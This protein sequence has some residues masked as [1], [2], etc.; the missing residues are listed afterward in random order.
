MKK[1]IIS[2]LLPVGFL[3]VLLFSGCKKSD[4]GPVILPP[5]PPPPPSVPA[6]VIPNYSYGSDAKMKMDIYLPA[7]RSASTKTL[8]LIHGG[9]WTAG[10]KADLTPFIDSF[11]R[12][13]PGWAFININYP[14]IDILSGTNRHPS[15]ILF[16]RRAMDTIKNNLNSWL[17]SNQFGMWGASA[18]GHLALM[19]TYTQNNDGLVKAVCNLMG[20]TDLRDCWINPPGPDTRAI[21]INYTGVLIPNIFTADQY[22]W[23]SPWYMVNSSNGKPTIGFHGTAD[24]L[25]SVT[26]SRKLKDKLTA[27]G[28]INQY[29]EYPGVGH[30]IWPSDKLH[31]MFNKLGA[32]MIQH[33]K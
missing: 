9:G 18:G 5:P 32:F 30:E 10:D 27:L 1:K 11:R 31:D 15:Q 16:I 8:V 19:H 33:V 20:P 22:D 13:L 24:V 6:L 26:Q 17:I 7:G 2:L 28:I 23:G 4:P 25:V 21:A 12:I 14:L 29:H 3:V